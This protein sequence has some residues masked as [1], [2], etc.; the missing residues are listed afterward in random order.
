VDGLLS[1]KRSSAEHILERCVK[2]KIKIK[3][4]HDFIKRGYAA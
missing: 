3:S 1:F 2:E 4:F